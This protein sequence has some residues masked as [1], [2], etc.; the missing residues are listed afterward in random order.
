VSRDE[1]GRV[2]TLLRGSLRVTDARRADITPDDVKAFG[3]EVFR[4]L[5]I[6]TLIHGNTTAEGANE[7][8]EMVE[9]V[10][11][12]RPLA[13]AEKL[14]SRTLILPPCKCCVS[15]LGRGDCREMELTS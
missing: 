3:K 6:E 8:Q 12:P 9:R 14:G 10:L 4:R 7:I 1:S 15:H 11:A 2:G 13:E 5:Y